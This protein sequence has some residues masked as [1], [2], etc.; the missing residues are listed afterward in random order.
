MKVQ[1]IHSVDEPAYEALLRIYHDSQPE[2]ELKSPGQLS[3]MIERPDYYFLAAMHD[4][5]VAGFTI[6]ICFPGS[7]AA[8]IEYMAV[9]RELRGQG[10]GQQLFRATVQF[11]SLAQRTVIIEVDSEES[12]S[13]DHADRVRRKNFYRRL[14]CREIEG[15]SYIMPPVSTAPPP[16]MDMLVYAANLPSVVAKSRVREWLQICYREVYQQPDDD[17]RIGSMIANLPEDVRLI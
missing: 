16:P 11:G 13:S 15:L 5:A 8:L 10:I 2:S 9:A 4:G 17:P 7:D 12:P 1:R 3:R 14:G 6:S